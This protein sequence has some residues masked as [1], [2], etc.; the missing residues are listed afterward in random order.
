MSLGDTIFA[1]ARQQGFTPPAWMTH[2]DIKLEV[3]SVVIEAKT[4]KLKA[5]WSNETQQDLRWDLANMEEYTE[6]PVAVE[7]K[8]SKFRSI[9]DD[10][11]GK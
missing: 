3:E 6:D 7:S 9:D 5:T 8:P 1:K 10:W 2:P 11:E 4:R